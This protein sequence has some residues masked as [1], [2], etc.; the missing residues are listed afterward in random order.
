MKFAFNL[1]DGAVTIVGAAPK[2][3]LERAVGVLR[4]VGGVVRRHFTDEEYRSFVIEQNKAKGVIPPDASDFVELP[5][6]WREPD[7]EFRL[8]WRKTGAAFHYDMATC[9]EITRERLRRERAPLLEAQDVEAM[10]ALE[11]N[12]TEK[13]NRVYAEKQ[14]L[15]DIT[16]DPRIDAAKSVEELKAI[17]AVPRAA[18]ALAQSPHG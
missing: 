8:A 7:W 10:R 9:G 1:P 18:P 17:S 2:E 4:M 5:D 12:D 14:R 6:D 16:V 13:L 15:R 11:A 3:Q